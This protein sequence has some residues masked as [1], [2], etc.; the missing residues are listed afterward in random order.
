M[1]CNKIYNAFEYQL[2]QFVAGEMGAFESGYRCG[3]FE[4]GGTV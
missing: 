3:S 1:L 2:G 4:S